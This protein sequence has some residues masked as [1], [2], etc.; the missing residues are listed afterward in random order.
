VIANNVLCAFTFTVPQTLF[1][2]LG[3]WLTFAA[4]T[5]PEGFLENAFVPLLG[6]IR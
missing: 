4:Q 2:F 6:E 5:K 1:Q 3:F